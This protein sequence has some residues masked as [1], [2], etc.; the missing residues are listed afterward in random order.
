MKI[1]IPREVKNNEY[2]V[3]LTPEAVRIITGQGHEVFVEK[4]A[5]SGS[6][7]RDDQYIK[8]GA[9]IAESRD[10]LYD[11]STLIVKVKEPSQKSISL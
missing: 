11:K 7:I 8:A 2:R 3:S 6:G 1:G 9:S 10:E 4:N 5:G